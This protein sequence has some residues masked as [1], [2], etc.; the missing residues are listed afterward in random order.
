MWSSSAVGAWDLILF[1]DAPECTLHL[2]GHIFHLDLHFVKL[3]MFLMM[4]I[5][6]LCISRVDVIGHWF[7]ESELPFE[8]LNP[9]APSSS[10]IISCRWINIFVVQVLI[11]I[12]IDL[13]YSSRCRGWQALEVSIPSVTKKARFCERRSGR[14]EIKGPRKPNSGW[15]TWNQVKSTNVHSWHW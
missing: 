8:F 7:C 15:K 6:D 4:F 14:L 13:N 9:Y 5:S 1:L 3:R 12:L 10:C 2:T 11:D